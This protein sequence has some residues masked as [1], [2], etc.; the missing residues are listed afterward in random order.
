MQP[1]KVQVDD[2]ARA[3]PRCGLPS[4]RLKRLDHYISLFF[5]PLIPIKRGETFLECNRCGGVFDETG[6]AQASPFESRSPQACPQCGQPV[7]PG[8]RYCPN[9]GQRI[10]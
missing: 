10:S 7:S 9:C 8:F 2:Q 3:C 5:I 6:H 1:K 4:A